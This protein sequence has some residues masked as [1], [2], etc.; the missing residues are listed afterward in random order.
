MRLNVSNFVCCIGLVSC[1]SSSV[2]TEKTTLPYHSEKY[3]Q[4]QDDINSLDNSLR[5]TAYR[6]NKAEFEYYSNLSY[7]EELLR[8]I[9]ICREKAK[10]VFREE[11]VELDAYFAVNQ[12][13]RRVLN[14]FNKR[15]DS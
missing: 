6:M 3:M 15:D 2:V 13:Y 4:L 7:G 8:S 11:T 12:C 9:K 10:D 14:N 1:G 5:R